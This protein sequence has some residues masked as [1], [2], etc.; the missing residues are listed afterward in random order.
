MRLIEIKT[1]SLQKIVTQAM[2]Q[3]SYKVIHTKCLIIS[4]ES[5]NSN[6][7]KN[8]HSYLQERRNKE[9]GIGMSENYAIIRHSESRDTLPLTEISFYAI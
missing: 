1:K 6:P 9:Q 4:F 7:L 3:A 5:E 8:L 2:L